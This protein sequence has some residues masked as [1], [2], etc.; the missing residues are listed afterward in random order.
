MTDDPT[1]AYLYASLCSTSES[2]TGL[3]N[4]ESYKSCHCKKNIDFHH[5]SSNDET[6]LFLV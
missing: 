3:Y 2:S 5:M 1:C 6:Y 4:T